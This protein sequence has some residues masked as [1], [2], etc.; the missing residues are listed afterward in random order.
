MFATTDPR[1]D[2][3]DR[4]RRDAHPTCVV[5][6]RSSECGLG[7]RFHVLDDGSVE[8]GFRCSRDHQGYQGVLHGGVIS[9][10][11]D[12]AMT[13]SLFARGIEAVTA[14]LSVRFRHPVGLDEP[15]VIR[16][17]V[18]RSQPPLQVLSAEIVQAG[19]VRATATGKFMERPPA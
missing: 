12:G 9:S 18:T 15:M 5:C 19:Q 2:V 6:G 10:L 11:L 3:L 7:L 16:A 8:A 4:T 14:E 13:N 17:R 1:Q